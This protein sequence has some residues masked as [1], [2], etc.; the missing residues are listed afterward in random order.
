MRSQKGMILPVILLAGATLFAGCGQKPVAKVN[1]V[2]ITQDE[3]MTEL[4]KMHNPA[5]GKSLGESVLE[6]LITN[7]IVLAQAENEK[8]MPTDADVQKQIDI[9]QLNP[10]FEETLK[11]S[12][13][14][15]ADYKSDCKAQLALQNLYTKDVKV[16]SKEVE[17]RYN[18][19]HKLSPT[20]FNTPALA[21]GQIIVLPSQDQAK[22]VVAIL[23]QNADF[24]IV[25]QKESIDKATG[26][27]GGDL[28]AVNLSDPTSKV[29]PALLN[30]LKTVPVGKISAP[31]KIQNVFVIVKVKK[32]SEAKEMSKDLSSWVIKQ[33]L[34]VEKA[35]AKG[36]SLQ[37]FSDSLR[38]KA[39]IEILRPSVKGAMNKSDIEA[40]IAK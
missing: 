2:G 16:S 4:E 39:K 34:L 27:R 29:E 28:P 8:V 17:D 11:Q 14:S 36:K 15:L 35:N 30:A 7:K 38:E 19:I 9:Q 21:Y 37:E 40:P 18:Q 10:Q 13:M 3:Y 1:G 32:R 31:I 12:G 33:S 23:N 20:A 5:T 22:K 6:K 25:A 24:S 26:A